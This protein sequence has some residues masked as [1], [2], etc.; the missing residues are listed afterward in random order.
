MVRLWQYRQTGKPALEKL[1]LTIHNTVLCSDMGLSISPC[2][3][4]LALCAA[5]E[6][7]TAPIK[8]SNSDPAK[9]LYIPCFGTYISC[10]S[11]PSSFGGSTARTSTSCPM[12]EKISWLKVGTSAL[13]CSMTFVE[14]AWILAYMTANLTTGGRR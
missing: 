2:G 6:V 5:P 8:S 13:A 14:S 10:F 7:C 1:E 11:V 4:M 9:N 3:N 12:V